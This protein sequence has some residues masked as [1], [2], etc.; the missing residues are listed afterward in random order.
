MTALIHFLEKNNAV[1]I[2]W[3]KN[4]LTERGSNKRDLKLA[5][6]LLAQVAIVPEDNL[7]GS[8]VRASRF[9]HA[10]LHVLLQKSQ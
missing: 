7:R 3:K 4:P 6:A 8:A 9:H 10:A 1:T 5:A 2:L